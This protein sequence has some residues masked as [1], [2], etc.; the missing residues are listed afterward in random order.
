MKIVA[1]IG[2]S[3]GGDI[4]AEQLIDLAKTVELIV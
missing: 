3:H 4:K 2:S 1:E